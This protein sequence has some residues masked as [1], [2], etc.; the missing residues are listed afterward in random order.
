MPSV[1]SPW[2][3]AIHLFRAPAQAAQPWFLASKASRNATTR[4]ASPGLR[5]PPAMRS[6]AMQDRPGVLGGWVAVAMGQ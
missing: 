1:N 3:V 5:A 4:A 6:V 2:K